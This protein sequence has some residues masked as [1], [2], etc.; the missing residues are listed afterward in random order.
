MLSLIS[1]EVSRLGVKTNSNLKE[2]YLIEDKLKG[3]RLSVAR[4]ITNPENSLT[5]RSIVN[6]I[7]QYHFGK[8]IAGNPNNFGAK[9]QKP[10]HPKLLDWLASDFVKNDWKIKRIHKLIMLS[11]TYRPVSYTHLTLPTIYSV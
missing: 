5:S 8:A 2:P 3:R 10:T 4:W 1:S 9:G 7:W 11:N 6:R